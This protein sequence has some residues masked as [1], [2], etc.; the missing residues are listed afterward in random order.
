MQRRANS[1]I[2][3]MALLRRV[4]REV[5]GVLGSARGGVADHVAEAVA[6][7]ELAGQVGL[8]SHEVVARLCNAFKGDDELGIHL[9]GH[10]HKRS[11][12]RCKAQHA[13]RSMDEPSAT[14]R[15]ESI[16]SCIFAFQPALF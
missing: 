5:Y 13:K 9:H 4:P 2:Q 8:A 10:Q 15:C 11:H 16:F 14:L 1:R 3:T 12:A 6:P 7:L